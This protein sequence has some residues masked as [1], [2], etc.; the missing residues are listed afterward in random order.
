MAQEIKDGDFNMKPLLVSRDN[1]ILDGHHRWA[2]AQVVD[3]K[4]IV[5]VLKIDLDFHDL[6]KYANQFSGPKKD[7]DEARRRF[8]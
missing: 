8:S 6:L 1:F 5:P 4:A 2:A 3:S 7:V